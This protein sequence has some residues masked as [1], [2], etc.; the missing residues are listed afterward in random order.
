MP[1]NIDTDLIPASIDINAYFKHT[2]PGKWSFDD[3]MVEIPNL[4]FNTGKHEYTNSLTSIK[5]YKTVDRIVTDIV[6]RK[7]VGNGSKSA[8]KQSIINNSI[9]IKNIKECTINNMSTVSKSSAHQKGC[10]HLQVPER[11]IRQTCGKKILA[12]LPQHRRSDIDDI[13]EN[14]LIVTYAHPI[15]SPI[16]SDPDHGHGEAKSC[17]R[18]DGYHALTLE[19]IRL[20]TMNKDIIDMNNMNCFHVTF[21]L[22]TVL[23]DGFYASI[24]LDGIDFCLK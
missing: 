5:T 17:G 22:T 13:S 20:S 6:G 16:V 15:I 23:A 8:E 14:E 18:R 10:S 1:L 9:N 19:L 4:N 7:L 24:E 3:F 12:D 21:Y 11:S 2:P